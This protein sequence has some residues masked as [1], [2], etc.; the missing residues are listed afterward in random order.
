M[1]L[2]YDFLAW[3]VVHSG[4]PTEQGVLLLLNRRQTVSQF[5]MRQETSAAAEVIPFLNVVN[6]SIR[7]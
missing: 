7:I 5:R 4:Y 6:T 1:G 2:A 3:F